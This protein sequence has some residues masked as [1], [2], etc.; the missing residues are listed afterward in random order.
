VPNNACTQL[1]G[2]G[3]LSNNLR[4]VASSRPAQQCATCAGGGTSTF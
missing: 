1:V 4:F 3:A 2:I